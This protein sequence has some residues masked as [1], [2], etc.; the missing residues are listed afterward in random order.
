MRFVAQMTKVSRQFANEA[1]NLN[2]LIDLPPEHWVAKG[3]RGGRYLAM[4][5]RTR[6]VGETSDDFLRNMLTVYDRSAEAKY[7]RPGSKLERELREVGALPS[8][9]STPSSS[10]PPEAS[11]STR[12]T[13]SP[14]CTATSRRLGSRE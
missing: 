1:P 3:P 5:I 7:I 11:R 4:G 8:N 12:R 6:E 13:P 9:P 10:P 2:T 14:R